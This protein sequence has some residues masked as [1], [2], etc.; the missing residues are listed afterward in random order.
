MKT[1]IPTLLY[2]FSFTRTTKLQF[3]YFLHNFNVNYIIM[4][5]SIKVYNVLVYL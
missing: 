4:L 1:K 2:Q 3:L 5:T